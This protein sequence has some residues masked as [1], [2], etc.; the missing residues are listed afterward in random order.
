MRIA[1]V[2]P[3]ARRLG[4]YH[5]IGSK[6]PHLGLQVLAQR[7]PAPHKVDII[8]EIFGPEPTDE[9]LRPDRYDLIGITSFTSTVSRA[10]EIGQICRERGIKTVMGGPHAWA[11]PDEAAQHVDSVAIGECD[12]IW[13]QIIADAEAGRLAP[14]YQ[15]GLPELVQGIGAAAQRLQPINGRYDVAAIQTSRGCPVNCDYCG[16][17]QFNGSRIRRR[18]IDDILEEWNLCPKPFVFVVDDNF[19]GTNT[20]HAEWAKELCRQIIAKGKKRLWFSQT[21][22]NMGDDM[23]GLRLAYKAGCRGMLVGFESFSPETLEGLGKRFNRTLLNDYERLVKG[24]HKAGISLFGAFI[25]GGPADDV[26]T[27]AETAMQSVRI[28]VD[29]IQITN[30]TPLP[31]TRLY[32]RLM[33]DNRIIAKAYPKDWER[34]SFTE[35]VYRPERMTAQEL[36]EAIFEL[37]HAAASERWVW[38]RTLKTLLR[39]R[40]LTTALFIHGMNKGWK[41]LATV[42]LPR[43]IDRYRHL[44]QGNE[45]SAAR[46]ERLRQAFKLFN[47]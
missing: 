31:G 30:L 5:T 32:Q 15:G 43:E 24:F 20:K 37:R 1:L 14:R 18:P 29:T 39:T 34:Y 25:I 33:D 7:V 38:K 26:N 10:Y 46:R 8:D 35:T 17:T 3:V 16:V 6:I 41:R 12:E 9:R 13:P 21:T 19:F 47:G 36:D 11:C 42:Q 28:G 4:G 22:I 2:N 23:E 40:S 44:F 45:A 27:V